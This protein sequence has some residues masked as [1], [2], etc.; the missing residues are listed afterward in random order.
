MK[1]ATIHPVQF[2]QFNYYDGH[3]QAYPQPVVR[4]VA[5]GYYHT[6][7]LDQTGA[8]FGAGL[9]EMGQLGDGST[10]S[11]IS[12]VEVS[13]GAQAVAACD[14]QSFVLKIDGTLLAAGRNTY[15][16]IG[17]GDISQ[18]ITFAPVPVSGT[19]GVVVSISAGRFHAALIKG[20][21][22][23]WGTGRNNHGQLGGAS[24]STTSFVKIFDG[25]RT[26]TGTSHNCDKHSL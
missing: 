25:A 26:T 18:Q 13:S 3:V 24:D 12:F 19:G 16:Q 7:M 23:V 14:H 21:G 1:Q 5:A 4:A 11:K 17:L 15:G 9:N 2:I 22:S 20:D 8:V 6:L 10:I